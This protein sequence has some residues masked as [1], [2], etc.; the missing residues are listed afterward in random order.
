MQDFSCIFTEASDD[1]AIGNDLF[2]LHIQLKMQCNN[3]E[4]V[5]EICLGIKSECEE[6]TREQSVNE[7]EVPLVNHSMVGRGRMCGHDIVLG[8][9]DQL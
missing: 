2:V 1:K 9:L 7:P 5:R 8:H 3:G 4:S 6:E